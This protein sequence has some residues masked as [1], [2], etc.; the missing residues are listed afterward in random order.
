MDYNEDKLNN[1]LGKLREQKPVLNDAE[2]L[3]D[4]IMHEIRNNSQRQN[5]RFLILLRAVSSA[6]AILLLGLFLFQQNK[7]N[8][9]SLTNT[10]THLNVIKINIDSLCI[11]RQSNNQIDLLETYFCYIK[12][13]SIKNNLLK[14]FTQPITN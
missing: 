9:A 10:P 5:S 12:Q 2:K 1:L 7:S 14:S 3:T 11:Q 13:N 6:A 4:D 8:A